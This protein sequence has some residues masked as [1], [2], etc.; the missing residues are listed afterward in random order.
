MR[1]GGGVVGTVCSVEVPRFCNRVVFYYKLNGASPAACV[2]ILGNS[3]G[4]VIVIVKLS[5]QKGICEI[6]FLS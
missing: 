2:S 1:G 5:V 4:Y 6:L 3:K